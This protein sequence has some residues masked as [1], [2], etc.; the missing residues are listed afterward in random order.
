LKSRCRQEARIR[1]LEAHRILMKLNTSN[2]A[3]FADLV[4]TLEG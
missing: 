1:V 2:R 4:E 3:A